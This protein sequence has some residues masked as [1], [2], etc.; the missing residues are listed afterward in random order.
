MAAPKPLWLASPSRFATLPKARA[1][2]VLAMAAALLLASL[3]S[4]WAAVPPPNSS[5]TAPAAQQADDQRDV[6]LYTSIVEALRHGESYYDAAAHALRAGDYP[7]RPFFTFRLPTLAMV[8][9]HLPEFAIIGLLF[10]LVATT[11]LA[12]GLRL[13]QALTNWRATVIA[14]ALLA[15]GLMAFVQADLWPFHEIWAGLLIA[16]SLA[17]RRPGRF[18][19]AVAIGLIAALVRETAGLYLIVMTILAWRD[20]QRREAFAWIGAGLCLG[21][22][23]AAHAYGVSRVTHP[24][25]PASQG[26]SGML[27]FGFFINSLRAGTALA[28]LPGAVGALFAALALF[29]WTAWRDPLATRVAATLAAY[30]L[31]LGIFSRP[32]TFYWVLMIA[33]LSLVGLVFVPDAL[34]DLGRQALDKRRIRITRV[35]R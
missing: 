20:G 6:V 15:G 12:W 14:M 34:R 16:L 5:D 32:D 8:Q 19:E 30:A 33:P 31:L 7:L 17:L 21:L 35:A 23:L 3:T 27:G 24:L 28:I 4:L 18:A 11:A 22:A 25:D 9:S 13:G 2:L 10:I 1:R 26:W 29:G